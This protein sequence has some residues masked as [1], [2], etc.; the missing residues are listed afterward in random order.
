VKLVPK[1]ALALFAGV[2]VVVA[3][4]TAW[5]IR[6]EIELFDED[7]RQ[8]QRIVGITAGASLSSQRTRDDAMRLARRV[9]KSRATIRV[10]YVSLA[11]EA[12]MALRPLVPVSVADVPK[13]GSWHQLVKPK[14]QGEKAD[15]LVTYVNA[16]VVDD[17]LGAIELVQPL[18][19]RAE[20]AWRG[21]WSA[22][23]SSLAMLVV[24]GLAMTLIGARIVGQPVSELIA[25]VRRVGKGDFDVFPSISRQDEFGELARAVRAMGLGLSEERQRTREQVE[26]RIQ[27][28]EQLRHA[29]RL[30]TLGKLA[31]VLAHEIGTPLNVIAGHAKLVA[32]GKLEGADARDSATEI[33]AQ[34]DRITGIVRRVLDYARRRPPKRALVRAAD[35]VSQTGALLKSFAAQN[36]VRLIYEASA[37]DI[38]L[39]ADPDQLQQTLINVVMNAIQAT[40]AGGS[41]TLGIELSERQIA[42]EG[43]PIEFI[44]FRVADTGDG[45]D[46]ATRARIFEPFF[47]TKPPGEGTGLGLSV[48][49]DIVEEHGGTIEVSSTRG[50]GSSFRI[51]LPRRVDDASANFGS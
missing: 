1:L 11:L 42:D 16:P 5:Q 27:A 23:A 33:G 6:R 25:A 3:G 50:H 14:A 51:H 38:D 17:A 39:E 40:P 46:D 29:E 7:V 4:L 13:P 8:N 20:Y 10:R 32:G 43:R 34:C 37:D 31:S 28:I 44:V 48:A 9:D 49:R 19:S 15:R 30:A 35:L 47:T 24:G 18:A 22:L 41:I 21:V 2:V 36:D 45:I 12:P 26:A